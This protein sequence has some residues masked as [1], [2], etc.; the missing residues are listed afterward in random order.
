MEASYTRV[1]KKDRT[2]IS[3]FPQCIEPGHKG[4]DCCALSI[5]LKIEF[6]MDSIDDLTNFVESRY[7]YH[8]ILLDLLMTINIAIIFYEFI[9][10]VVGEFVDTTRRLESVPVLTQQS[11]LLENI[12]SEICFGSQITVV[13]TSTIGQTSHIFAT[14][15]AILNPDNKLYCISPTAKFYTTV[16]YQYRVTFFT[17]VFI[18]FYS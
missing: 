4:G 12:D 13:S 14:C 15:S 10:V 9:S 2:N 1:R 3:C 17:M 8:M 7:H 6:E 16:G 5:E 18:F 11:A